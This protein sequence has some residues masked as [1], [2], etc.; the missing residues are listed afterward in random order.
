MVMGAFADYRQGNYDE[1]IASAK[2][3]L[4]LY[5]SDRRR[6]LR[7]V[8]HRAELLPADPDV[9][10]D[11]KEARQTIADDGGSGPALARLPNMSTTPRKR[12]ASPATSWPAR[13]C[14][15][16]ATISSAANTS[17]PIK[18]FRNVVENYSNTRH[19]EEA[20]ARLTES[21]LRDGPDRRSA[22]GR[23]GARQQLSRQPVVQGF[24]QAAAERRACSRARMPARGYPR[25][26]S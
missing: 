2:R 11:Q 1:A 16:A 12:S 17:P 8:H 26:A 13:K 4:T 23:R 20:L 14:R 5:P 21:L 19:V 24:L 18:R 15:S 22:D 6:G 10:Q 3:Y 7:P 25:P 9:T